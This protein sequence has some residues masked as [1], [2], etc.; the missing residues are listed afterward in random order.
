MSQQDYQKNTGKDK[1]RSGKKW[2]LIFLWGCGLATG[3]NTTFVL[4]TMLKS[5]E[6]PWQWLVV[7]WLLVLS[8]FVI[9]H[10]ADRQ[11]D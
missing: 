4:N 10:I 7:F 9:K 3:I 8:W 11:R 5:G 1:S 6:F 2:K